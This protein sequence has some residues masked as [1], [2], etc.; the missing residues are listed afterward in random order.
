MPAASVLLAV[1]LFTAADP[2]SRAPIVG[3]AIWPGTLPPGEMPPDTPPGPSY[4]LL[5]GELDGKAFPRGLRMAPNGLPY[6]PIFSFDL[7]LN[8]WLWRS[9]GLYLFGDIRFWG[10]CGTPGQ[11]HGN[12]DYTKREFDQLAGL[13]WNYYGPLELRAFAFAYNNLNRG[14]SQTIPGGYND[15]TA[16]EQRWYLGGEYARLGQE[17]F[18][19]SRANFVSLGYYPSKALVALSGDTFAPGLFAR[20]YVTWDL[21]GNFSYVFG[22]TQLIC[23]KSTCHPQLWQSDV[24]IAVTPFECNRLL[25]IRLGS[26]FVVDVRSGPVHSYSLPYLSLRLNY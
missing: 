14:F 17:G 4:K 5:W 1:A 26:E 9:Q 2:D 15:G 11:T 16:V 18:N 21:P 12:W 25:E 3:E 24:G 19:V 8:V 23:D 13:A 20:A 6:H 22:D 7:D 10:Q